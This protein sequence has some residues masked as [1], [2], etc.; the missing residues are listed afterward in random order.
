[1]VRPTHVRW[2]G[3]LAEEVLVLLL[4]VSA[5]MGIG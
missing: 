3:G 5:W 1:L 2:G 4:A